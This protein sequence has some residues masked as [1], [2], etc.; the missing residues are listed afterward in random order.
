MFILTFS[1]LGPEAGPNP[2]P[3][4]DP[5]VIEIDDLFLL[6]MNFLNSLVFLAVS[7]SMGQLLIFG[8]V[9]I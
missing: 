3:D 6:S 1:I 2:D 5:D 4:A 7:M 8:R 9:F